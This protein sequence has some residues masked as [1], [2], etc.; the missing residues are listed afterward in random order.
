V[1][2]GEGT[3]PGSVW[4]NWGGEGKE[5]SQNKQ[6]ERKYMEMN[7]LGGSNPQVNQRTWKSTV[8]AKTNGH[9]SMGG[10][11]TKREEITKILQ[12]AS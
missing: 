5:I 12:Q 4:R 11:R 10:F 2:Y 6:E 9:A 1:T 7:A 3:C 8:L